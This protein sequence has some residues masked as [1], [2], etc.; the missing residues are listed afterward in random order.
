MLNFHQSFLIHSK[1]FAGS[2][3]VSTFHHLPASPLPM[4][5]ILFR[6]HFPGFSASDKF[7]PL[8]QECSSQVHLA[9]LHRVILFSFF[10]IITIQTIMV[11]H[12]LQEGSYCIL[13]N[14]VPILLRSPPNNWRSSG[15]FEVPILFSDYGFL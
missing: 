1:L 9:L 2:P 3:K 15:N 6:P 12:C 10:V 14:P 8:H 5:T 7:Y 4:V 13:L 11:L